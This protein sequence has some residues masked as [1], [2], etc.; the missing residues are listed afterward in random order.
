MGFDTTMSGD[1]AVIAGWKNTLHA[2]FAN[3]LPNATLAARHR[4]MAKPGRASEH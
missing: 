2:T 1:A 3:V 4:K